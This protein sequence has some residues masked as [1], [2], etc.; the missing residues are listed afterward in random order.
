MSKKDDLG[1][2]RDEK[3]SSLIAHKLHKSRYLCKVLLQ[4]CALLSQLDKH[5]EALILARKAL[6]KG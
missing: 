3:V 6:W 5:P 2:A 1:V 4:Q